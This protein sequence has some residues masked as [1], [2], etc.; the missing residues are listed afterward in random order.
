[1]EKLLNY[2]ILFFGGKGGVGKSTSSSAFALTAAEKGK[3]T[4]LVSTDPAHNLSDLFDTDIGD[5]RKQLTEN[6]WGM[7]I[8][9]EKE[10][11]RYINQVKDN[12]KGLVKSHMAEEVNR[13]IDMAAVSPGAEEAALFDKLVQIV[14]E[15]KEH[16]DIIVF[17]TAPTGH[18]V[19]L[20][21]LP[22]MMEAWIEGMLKR[23][24]SINENYSQWLNDGEPVDD[25]IYRVLMNRKDRFSEA[26]K[27]LIN[28]KRTAYIYVL[29]PEKLPVAETKRALQMLEQAKLKVDTLIVNKCLPEHAGDSMFI[30]KR[31]K[32]ER[33][34]IQQIKEEFPNQKKIFLPLLEEDITSRKALGDIKEEYLFPSLRV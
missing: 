22:E 20:L 7:E 16:F 10:S 31:K 3:R 30:E 26:R 17:D 29:I 2:E 4:L 23:R 25:P 34:Y 18:T 8:S 28:N 12:L 5:K 32:Q 11:K 14:L 15:E 13:Q 1:M 33:S 27:V 19:R 24:Q 6:L 21:S 9:S